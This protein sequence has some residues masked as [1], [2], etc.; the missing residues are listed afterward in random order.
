MQRF[1]RI[2]L[3]AIGAVAAIGV[4]AFCIIQPPHSLDGPLIG[5]LNLQDFRGRDIAEIPTAEARAQIPEP[6]DK[7]GEYLPRITVALEDRRFTAHGGVDFRAL[8]AAIWRDVRA[9]H[10]ISGGSTITEQLVK[11]GYGR[12]GR[13]WFGKIE[14]A[15]AACKIE[16]RWDKLRILAEYLN[17]VSY[18]NRR[19][20]PEAAAR[21][22]F[23][24][25][26]E[27]LTLGE[28]I[29]LAGIPQAPSRFNPWEHPAAAAARY[30]RDLALLAAEGVITPDQRDLLATPPAVQHC[31]PPH[32]APNFVDAVL[33]ENPSLT[34]TRGTVRTTL[35]LDLQ[36][37]AEWAVRNHL[38][39]LNRADVTQAA[40][41][42]V[43]NST[44]AVRALVGSSDYSVAQVNG[45]LRPRSC[46]S[47][48][49]PFIYLSAI[50]QHII[51]A[52]TILPDT[53]DAIRDA[54]PDYD[55]VDFTRRCLGPVRV[56]EALACSLNVPAVV[57]L[58]RIGARPA[59]YT[60]GKWGFNFDK[61]F[62]DYGAGFILGNAGI[63]L[64]DLAS[65]YAG[66]ARGGLAMPARFLE[67]R[68]QPLTRISSPD[69]AAI[70]TDILCDND[71]RRRAFGLG[72]ALALK[73]RVAA[74]TGTSSG[75]RD[76]W[77]VGFD[78]EH[79]VAVWAG[80]FNGR[81]LGGLLA[82]RAAAPL[83]AATMNLLLRNDHPVPEPPSTLVREDV[84]TLTGL[85]PCAKSPGT[86]TELFLKG[87]QPAQDASSWFS[88]AGAPILPDDYAVWCASADNTIGAQIRPAPRI[89]T[90]LDG[91]HYIIDRIL[92]PDQQM[93]ELTSTL[94]GN[95]RWFVNGAPIAPQHDG[96]IF[97]QLSPGAW[98]IRAI[99]TDSELTE[100]ITV[101]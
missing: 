6:L 17:R 100:A 63:R 59:F 44:G 90:P 85:L 2:I 96:R 25:S 76:A 77:T 43:E 64:V 91:A 70:I 93:L 75:F 45:A 78:K 14:E 68:L 3:C 26:A 81:P 22:Y 30:H 24:K 37:T 50:D 52:A 7:M 83:W 71:A 40:M 54:Y 39:T 41:V 65:A 46:G 58:S 29:F 53:P 88:N 38:T 74:K 10:I 73:T 67:S 56:R 92:S 28:A 19:L 16:W 62:D 95:V 101:E 82:I 94:P 47:T 51:T 4:A 27:H 57:T 13:S 87:T 1:R 32:L 60:L 33:R 36:T 11:L 55:P 84:C 35:D 12:Q 15:I 69:A 80:N 34:I 9:G 5:T 18:S 20:G 86:I 21:A 99:S 72:S 98:R 66:I 23:G 49:K 89:L 61:H 79:T 8:C 31:D 48:L 97:W 42:I